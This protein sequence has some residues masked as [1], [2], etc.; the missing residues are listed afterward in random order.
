MDISCSKFSRAIN[1]AALSDGSHESQNDDTVIQEQ[2]FN[3]LTDEGN[4]IDQGQIRQASP[5][6]DQSTI[7]SDTNLELSQHHVGGY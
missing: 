6:G 4:F 1:F 5:S 2:S 7:A 3:S